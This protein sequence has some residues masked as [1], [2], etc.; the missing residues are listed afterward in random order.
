MTK[1]VNNMRTTITPDQAAE[2]LLTLNR[3]LEEHTKKNPKEAEVVKKWSVVDRV[4]WY[5]KEAYIAGAIEGLQKAA[6]ANNMTIME[7]AD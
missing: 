5:I 1:I 2:L 3:M 6:A 7:M 4:L